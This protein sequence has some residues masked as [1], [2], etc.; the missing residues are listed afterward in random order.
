MLFREIVGKTIESIRTVRYLR[1]GESNEEYWVQLEFTDGTAC[2]I[3]PVGYE[4][5]GISIEPAEHGKV[6]YK[7]YSTAREIVMK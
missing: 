2:L 3:E 7:I 4:T 5:E 6:P 1:A